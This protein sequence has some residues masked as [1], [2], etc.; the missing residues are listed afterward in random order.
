MALLLLYPWAEVMAMKRFL[1]LVILIAFATV[2]CAGPN[3]VNH[4]TPPPKGRGLFEVHPE[5]RS[6]APPLKAGL[7]AA[8]WVKWMKPD[9]RQDQFEKDYQDCTQAGKGDPDQEVMVQE[10]LALRGYESEPVPCPEK[11]KPDVAKMA[12][13]VGAALLI[14][15]GVALLC[16]VTIV[17]AAAQ[18]SVGH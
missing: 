17:G 4:S 15:A 7:R 6:S 8:E 18:L 16:A 9:F 10:C 13:A 3:K 14:T 11:E 1:I 5:P 12:K 2:N